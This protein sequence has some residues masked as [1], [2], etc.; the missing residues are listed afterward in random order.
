MH[1]VLERLM[2]WRVK[3]LNLEHIGV[4]QALEK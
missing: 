1:L 4:C 3:G 2:N